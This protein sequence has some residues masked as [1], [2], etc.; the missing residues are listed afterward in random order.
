MQVGEIILSLKTGLNPRM[1][2]KLNSAGATCNYVTGKDVYN[3]TINIT[4]R[5]DKITQGEVQLI[6]KR[7][8][9]E[10]GDVLFVSTGTG[11][12]GR[13]AIVSNYNED[14]AVSETAYLLKPDKAL[15][16]SRFLMQSLLTE[17]AISQYQPKISKGSVPHLKTKDLL[18]VVIP[19]PDLHRQDQLSYIIDRF[20]K[21]CN[22]ISAGIP[23]EIE[24]RQKQY[25]Y[26]RDTLLNFNEKE[27]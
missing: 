10:N 12:V 20:E 27:N 7:A 3:N 14:W 11:T 1:N 25:E 23:A 6:N 24:A 22:D 15:V 19:V 2:F 16:Q 4:E 21:Y 26:Y 8:C 5:T 13:M 17:S 18:K 9:I